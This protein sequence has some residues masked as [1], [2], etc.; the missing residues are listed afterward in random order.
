M[1]LI[2]KTTKVLAIGAHPD[3]IEFGCFGVLTY[4]NS[5]HL[6]VMSKG[7]GAGDPAVRSSE[8]FESAKLLDGRLTHLDLPDTKLSEP[9]MIHEIEKEVK[10]VQPEIVFTMSE[11]DTHQDHRAVATATLIALRQFNGPVFAYGTPSSFDK[12]SPQTVVE[13]DPAA[14]E[15]KL[16]AI[17]LHVSQKDKQYMQPEFIRAIARYWAAM[18]RV[19]MEYGEAFRLVKWHS[20]FTK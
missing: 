4:A 16:T 3:D 10:Q 19:G 5:P 20:S 14:M 12:F 15:L 13:L 11:E 2:I 6:L 18:S 1:E 8:A 7:E 9:A 17:G